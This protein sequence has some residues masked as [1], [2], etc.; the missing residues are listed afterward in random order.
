[1]KN[2][3]QLFAIYLF[4]GLTIP[5]CAQVTEYKRELEFSTEK[6]I[7]KITYTIQINGP[8]ENWMADVSIPYKAQNEFKLTEAFLADAGGN[9][10]RKLKKRDIETRNLRRRGTFY[11]DIWATEFK[12]FHNQYPYILH[13]SY[14]TEYSNFI[15]LFRLIPV[16]FTE[17]P[18]QSAVFK[19]KHPSELKIRFDASDAFQYKHYNVNEYTIHEWEIQNYELPKEEQFSPPLRET[20]PAVEIMPEQFFFKT[21]GLADSWQN[22]GKWVNQIN[23]GLTALTSTEKFIVDDLCQNRSDTL[24]L[25]RTLY[26]HLQEN[27]RYVNV[28]IEE[29]GLV[30]FPASYVCE[31]KYG[32]CKALTIYMKALL[33]Y[34]GIPSFYTLVYAGDNPQTLNTNLPSSQFN[35]VILTIPLHGDTLWLENTA[36]IFPAGYIGEST[37]NRKALMVT[38]EGGKIINL[39]ALT[40][41]DVQHSSLT[42]FQLDLNGNGKFTSQQQLKGSSYENFTYYDRFAT[43]KE[44]KEHLLNN[45]DFE[46]INNAE[47]EVSIPNPD[48]AKAKLIVKADCTNQFRTFGSMIIIKP[49]FIPIPEP[50]EP[51][52]RM[53][54]IKIQMPVNRIDTTIYE[55][56]FLSEFEIELPTDSTIRSN[57]GSYRQSFTADDSTLTVISAFKLKATCRD[58]AEYSALYQF[59]NGIIQLQKKSAVILKNH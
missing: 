21:K 39:P 50:E 22:L 34:V 7:E 30:P 28:S 59:F 36:D 41:K 11:T 25:I 1:M 6:L 29:G 27:T 15:G 38:P 45:L 56:K 52:K 43:E 3:K 51:E 5:I 2:L 55:L 35:H 10:I 44:Q 12:L 14:E 13:Y 8:E 37:Q 46:H 53:N 31:N 24:Q 47:W 33:E 16:V 4:L 49:Y 57:F 58:K 20:I 40:L 42:V 9:I 17:V 54:D 19:V 26:K 32:D 48:S 18:T 23:N